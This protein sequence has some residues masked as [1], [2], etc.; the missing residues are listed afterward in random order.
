MVPEPVSKAIP[1]ISKLIPTISKPITTISNTVTIC[2]PVTTR[3]TQEETQWA[4]DSDEDP[5][6]EEGYRTGKT[7]R[8]NWTNTEEE[9]FAKV[10][11]PDKL[12]SGFGFKTETEASRTEK[13]RNRTDGFGSG[14]VGYPR[15]APATVLFGEWF[16]SGK[17][18]D[19]QFLFEKT[20]LVFLKKTKKPFGP[21][22]PNQ[23]VNNRLEWV[24]IEREIPPFSRLCTLLISRHLKWNRSVQAWRGAGEDR[25]WCR[26]NGA[27]RVIR[28]KWD[29]DP[30]EMK[31]DH[32]AH[33]HEVL[34]LSRFG[35]CF[36]HFWTNLPFSGWLPLALSMMQVVPFSQ[37]LQ[38]LKLHQ[39][40]VLPVSNNISWLPFVLAFG[41][42]LEQPKRPI[43]DL[44]L[45]AYS[46][47]SMVAAVLVIKPKSGNK[48]MDDQGCK[49]DTAEERMMIHKITKLKLAI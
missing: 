10:K 32:N 8:K 33:D 37:R 35:G 47:F 38:Q 28:V 18:S 15:D 39:L 27:V 26:R 30:C 31:L 2:I 49:C 20:I 42:H 40:P 19:Q 34:W 29:G 14:L 22:S 46:V 9:V 23:A 24:N 48:E 21:N 13:P 4:D 43:V 1:T 11:L 5:E 12:V 36:W 45:T 25:G 17:P 7:V 6:E 16:R 41:L 3:E 44:N